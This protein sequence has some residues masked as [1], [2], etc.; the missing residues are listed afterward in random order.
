MGIFSAR[1]KTILEGY[2]TTE[3]LSFEEAMQELE[4]IVEK[5][6]QGEISLEQSLESFERGV[7]LA[8]HSQSLLNKA[9]QKVQKLS[10][11]SGEE[12]LVDFSVESND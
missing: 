6:E 1:V 10:T 8:R 5:M 7:K 4:S 2:M 9:E 3:K 11:E 12:T